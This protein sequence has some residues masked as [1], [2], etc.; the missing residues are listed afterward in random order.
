M[1]M[2]ALSPQIRV[3]GIA[4]AGRSP[5][6]SGDQILQVR[7]RS[8]KPV[9]TGYCAFCSQFCQQI[10]HAWHAESDG[11]ECGT[12]FAIRTGDEL[13]TFDRL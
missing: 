6:H 5:H 13:S 7:Q 3:R 8:T 12:V 1:P 10:M 9:I 11:C 4:L 2:R